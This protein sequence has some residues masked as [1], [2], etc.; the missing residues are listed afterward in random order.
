MVTKT[1]ILV[2]FLAVIGVGVVLAKKSGALSAT[3]TDS[4][5]SATDPMQAPIKAMENY[6]SVSRGNLIFSNVF[7]FTAGS[8]LINNTSLQQQA[9]QREYPD[10]FVIQSYQDWTKEEY[11]RNTI[12]NHYLQDAVTTAKAIPPFIPVP[13][14]QK[15]FSFSRASATV[16]STTKTAAQIYS[17]FSLSGKVWH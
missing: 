7:P 6:G 13:K 8:S 3:A 1:K 16:P 4:L 10:T 14:P 9:A 17:P 15:S 12:F 11:R 5:L 2:G